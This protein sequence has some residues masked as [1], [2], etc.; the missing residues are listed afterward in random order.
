MFNAQRIKEIIQKKE[1]SQKEVIKRAG[2]SESTFYSLYR[3]GSQKNTNPTSNF[4]EAIAD[5]LECKIDDFFDRREEYYIGYNINH[6]HG[7]GNK[8]GS[9]T[10]SDCKKEVEY[11]K[12]L[13]EEK[14][15]LIQLL[16]ARHSQ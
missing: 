16:I 15:R 5:V 1:L 4:L 11:L 9:V 14:E 12:K 7:N 3:D 6:I 10:L 8:V 13:L 2:V